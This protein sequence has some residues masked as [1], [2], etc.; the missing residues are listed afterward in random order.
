MPAGEISNAIRFDDLA[1]HAAPAMVATPS[2]PATSFEANPIAAMGS[3]K[4]IVVTTMA[5]VA[6]F[7]RKTIGVSVPFIALSY[8]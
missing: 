1:S 5:V 4:M 8:K 6:D 7:G 2:T 3:N